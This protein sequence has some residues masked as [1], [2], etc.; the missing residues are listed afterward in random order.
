M[1][2]DLKPGNILT[3]PDGT[4]KLV[5]F[6]IAKPL[7]PAVA[8]DLTRTGTGLFTPDYASPEQVSGAAIT[9]ASDVYSLGA[10]LYQLLTG[11]QAHRFTSKTPA[12][13]ERTICERET[14][15]PSSAIGALD[16][17]SGAIGRRPAR[18]R[19]D[20][21]SQADA[22]G[23][24]EAPPRRRSGHDRDESAAQGS[25]AALRVGRPPAAGHHE[26]SSR[27]AGRRSA[28]PLDVSDAEVRGA[29]S[30]IGARR[31]VDRGLARDRPR[32][33]DERGAARP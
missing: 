25:G 8:T 10:V 14:P 31:T 22:A 1:H 2:R 26:P 15:S 30:R 28:G 18:R 24:P 23:S 9:T 27:A 11:L 19:A 29:A 32:H 4:I 12:D 33:D 16:A 7:D 17:A 6:G 5:D 3:T 21:P 13:V 20:C